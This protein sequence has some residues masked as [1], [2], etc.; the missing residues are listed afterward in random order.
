MLLTASD[1]TK[2]EKTFKDRNS[3]LEVE[4]IILLAQLDQHGDFATLCHSGSGSSLRIIR[5]WKHTHTLTRR[6]VVG[7]GVQ[8]GRV[9]VSLLC[10]S[11][12]HT[13]SYSRV[14]LAG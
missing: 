7:C 4:Q 1:A 8:S 14:V 5:G 12:F 2:L 3:G 10:R 6:V 11:R 13:I 9:V